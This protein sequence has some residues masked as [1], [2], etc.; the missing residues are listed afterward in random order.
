MLSIKWLYTTINCNPTMYITS[1][2]LDKG[3]SEDQKTSGETAVSQANLHVR[4]HEQARASNATPKGTIHLLPS[5]IIIKS[6]Y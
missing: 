4:S 3:S 6:K 5:T 1:A 2:D